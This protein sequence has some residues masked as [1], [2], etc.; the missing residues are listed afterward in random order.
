[1]LIVLEKV[2]NFLL[3]SSNASGHLIKWFEE[4]ENKR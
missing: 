2:K 4:E 3:K 1:M